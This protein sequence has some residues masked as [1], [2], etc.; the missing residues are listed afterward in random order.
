MS[1]LL[2]CEQVA[3]ELSSVLQQRRVICRSAIDVLRTYA[4]IVSHVSS[5][6]FLDNLLICCS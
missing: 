6:L 4:T 3:A 5:M 1:V 2:Q